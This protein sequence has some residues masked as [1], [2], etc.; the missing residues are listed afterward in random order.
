[1]I[2]TQYGQQFFKVQ[3][4][5][6][7][8]AFNPIGKKSK[9]KQS[10]FGAN[11][12]FVTMND[13]DFNGVENLSYAGKEPFLISGPGEYEK[14]GIFVKGFETSLEYNKVKRINTIYSLSFDGINICFLGSLGSASAVTSEIKS[15]IGDVDVLFVTI[16]GGDVLDPAEAH[17]LALS[18]EAKV[19]IPMHY[20]NTEV[21]DALNLFL[22]EG[23][24]D[25]KPVDKLTLKKKDLELLQGGM[26]ALKSV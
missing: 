15:S 10:R 3:T 20:E 18:F 17:K 11:I 5:D 23:G 24:N 12:A 22:K 1:M 14:D 8:L 6:T 13:P 9:L 25:V 4:G 7:V 26:V 16:G 21:K 2:I 19:V